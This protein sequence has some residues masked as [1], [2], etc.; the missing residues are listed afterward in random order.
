MFA[1]AMTAVAVRRASRA[2]RVKT[3]VSRVHAFHAHH[4]HRPA[5]PASSSSSSS[6]IPRWPEILHHSFIR[7][8]P[9]SLSR[10]VVVVV[11]A[12]DRVIVFRAPFVCRTSCPLSRSPKNTSDCRRIATSSRRVAECGTGRA[13]DGS[14]GTR[15]RA[16]LETGILAREST[17]DDA[18]SDRGRRWKAAC[19]LAVGVAVGAR[20]AVVVTRRLARVGGDGGAV[21]TREEGGRVGTRG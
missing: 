6:S 14:R 4:H 18:M 3:S 12:R 2:S 21:E 16:S 11:T 5:R 1:T 13:R 17:V 15:R 10:V 19:A 20:A 9:R 7:S 8:L